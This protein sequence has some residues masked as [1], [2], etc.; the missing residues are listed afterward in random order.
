MRALTLALAV[1]ATVAAMPAAAA[2]FAFETTLSGPAEFPPNASPGTGLAKLWFDED[3]QLMTLDVTFSGLLGT[4]AAAH[5]HGPTTL[6]GEGNAG[7]MTTTPTFAGFPLGV[8][9][10]TYLSTFDMTLASSY[11]PSFLNNATNLGS[12]TTASATLLS[13]LKD[14][15]AY[16]NIHTTQFP[17]G[18]I[19]GFLSLAPEPGTWALMLLGFG[20]AGAALRARR[21]AV[22]R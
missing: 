15:K 6:P 17:G 1:A 5:I 7:V 21:L 8:T 18:E 20:L 19:R 3:A 22:V 11:N 9:S 10:G 4:T 13:A 12:T 2:T 14:G 16:L